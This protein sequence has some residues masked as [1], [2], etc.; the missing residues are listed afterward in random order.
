[1]AMT[2]PS[3]DEARES[4]LIALSMEAAQELLESEDPP[5]GVVLH[6]LRLGSERAKLE[7]LKLQAEVAALEAKTKA[8]E[9][10]A[11][12]DEQFE[13][14]LRAFAGYRSSAVADD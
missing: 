5:P 11:R 2:P 7:S 8:L 4:K 1:M 3:S 12:T 10:Q 9:A 14:A 6:F 13:A